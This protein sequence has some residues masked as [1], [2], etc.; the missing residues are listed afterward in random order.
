MTE[1]AYTRLAQHLSVLA[2]G[3]PYNTY[4]VDILRES[5]TREEAEILLVLPTQVAPFEP[6]SLEEVSSYSEYSEDDLELILDKLA[7]RGMLFKGDDGEGKKGYALH[8]FGFGMP[9]AIFW[10]NEDTPYARRMA[11]LCIRHSSS[12]VL[13]KAFGGAGTKVYRWIP[14]K[15]SIEFNKQSVLPYANIEEIISNTTVIAGVN[16]NC[17]VMSRLKGR[18]PCGYP[19]DVCMKYDDLAE[20]VIDVGIGR[21]LSKDEAMAVNLK[22]EEAGC[23]HFADNVV[24]GEIKHACNCCPCCCWSLGNFNRRRIPRDLLMACQFIRITDLENCTGCEACVEACPINAVEMKDG[25]PEV[26]GDWC[27][28]CGVC[29]MSCPSDAISMVRREGIENPLPDLKSLSQGR[30]AEKASQY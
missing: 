16:C 3:P 10:P 2:V 9:Q 29:N 23:V 12:E 28:G 26:D 18:D 15:K 24:E 20:Y 13:T 1:D 30:L 22:A 5:L 11:E 25:F 27:I 14:T 17:R 7:A 4:L 8:Q 6:V 19:L 21:R